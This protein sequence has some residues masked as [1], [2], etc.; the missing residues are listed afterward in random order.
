ML[1]TK[2]LKLVFICLTLL[3]LVQIP[4]VAADNSPS[5]SVSFQRF[6]LTI[7]NNTEG[8][9]TVVDP[10]GGIHVA[11][12]AY[13]S[14]GGSAWPVYY[15]YCA[16]NCSLASQWSNPIVVGDCGAWGG[17]ARLALTSAGQP[18]LMWFNEPLLTEDGYYQY[19]E[20]N[21]GC[22]N[23]ANW[24]KSG[25]L[26]SMV[27]DSGSGRYFALDPQDHPRYI[28]TDT[29]IDH[30]G[31]YYA[32]CDAGCT[33]ISNW[34]EVQITPD[35]LLYDFSMAVNASGRVA[36]AYRSATSYP[37][38]LGYFQCDSNCSQAGSWESI[39]LVDNLGSG[40]ALSLRLNPQGQPRL[41]YY[42]GYLGSGNADNDLLVYTWC[43]S[44][45]TQSDHWS[46][47][48]VGLPVSYG[49]EV[50]LTLDS[51]ARPQ[52]AYYVDDVTNSVNGLG[53]ATCSANCQSISA[54]WQAQMV[55]SSDDLDA[56][57]PIPP[58]APCTYSFW[59]EVGQDPSLALDAGDNPRIGYTARHYQGGPACTVYEDIRL[60]RFALTANA[61]AN[62]I[63]VYLPLVT[64]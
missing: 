52:L 35:Y 53:Y 2:S 61:S 23:A 62:P 50:D 31:T 20:C 14:S 10:S 38:T 43:D 26:A 13:T 8:A 56:S 36:I 27:V 22:T 63:D 42:S 47:Y 9:T 58:I 6:W 28:Y 57:D 49:K 5:A 41:A 44:S 1:N 48:Q 37:D 21:A 4:S 30:T 55:E 54:T 64:R 16:S 34:H 45:C 7:S 33:T 51:Q 24:T 46:G 12:S 25:S 39:T 15:T 59:L 18:R 29:G 60:T 3:L 11:F 40:N 17:D 32:Y 19:A